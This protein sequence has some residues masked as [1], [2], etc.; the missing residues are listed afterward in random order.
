MADDP[1]Y[2]K[3]FSAAL[4]GAAEQWRETFRLEMTAKSLATASGASGD[5]LVHLQAGTA[6][7]AVLTQRTGLS[8]Q[9]VQQLL[10]QLEA[11][12]LVRREVDAND[13]RAKHVV[14]T[15]QGR[16]ALS[17]RQHVEAQLEERLR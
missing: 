15:E 5:M 10:D 2:T 7:Q 11:A 8:K 4:A 14:L 1:A 12:S 13:K 16:Q 9:A 6:P 17:E 3:S